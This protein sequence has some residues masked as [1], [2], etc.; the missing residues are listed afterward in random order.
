MWNDLTRKNLGTSVCAKE[1]QNIFY[2]YSGFLPTI[3]CY[4]SNYGSHLYLWFTLK[5]AWK[6]QK[7]IIFWIQAWAILR[8]DVGYLIVNS[9]F[10][11]LT[12]YLLRTN[13]YYSSIHSYC[14]LL[15]RISLLWICGSFHIV[16]HGGGDSRKWSAFKLHR[17]LQ[18]L[19]QLTNN[20]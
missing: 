19:Q 9:F 11:C 20:T 6:G 10:N 18:L 15:T 5:E 7:W 12:F 4:F 1:T 17:Y 13:C 8:T 3:L 14:L 16:L 2:S